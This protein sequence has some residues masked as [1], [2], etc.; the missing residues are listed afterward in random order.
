MGSCALSQSEKSFVACFSLELR[1]APAVMARVMSSPPPNEAQALTAPE[2][3]RWF[4][5]EI[6]PHER[7]LRSYLQGSFPS[8]PDVDDVVQESYLRMLRAKTAQPIRSAK[9]FLF[10]VARRLALDTVRRERASP[11]ERAGGL[12]ALHIIDDRADVSDDVV[13]RERVALLGQAIADLPAGCRAVFI[14]HKIKGHSRRETATQLGLAE[15]TVEVQTAKAM[16]RCGEFL[17]RRGLT[18]RFDHEAR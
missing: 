5:E 3:A 1:E 8:V 6:Q 16:R 12:E 15:K 17:R 10:T 13:R 11:I 7:S 18:G 2:P 14:L 4:A 9:A